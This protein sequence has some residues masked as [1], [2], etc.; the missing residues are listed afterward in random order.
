MSEIQLEI[1]G[2]NIIN[3]K[4]SAALSTAVMFNSMRQ[5][6]LHLVNW[7]KDKRLSG[8]RPRYL[9]VDTGRL[10]ASI[11]AGT[12]YKRGDSWMTRIGT[13]VVYGRIHEFGGFAGRNRSVRIPARPYLRPA[14]EDR[15]NQEDITSIFL[16]NITEALIRG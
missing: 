5:S 4:V 16:K 9:G 13:N 8:P 1:R 10:R 11:V 12:P 2:L 3:G 6:A 15:G 14:V 7:S